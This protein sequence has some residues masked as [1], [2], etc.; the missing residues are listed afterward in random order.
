MNNNDFNSPN[1][2]DQKE[3]IKVG[4]TVRVK[5]GAKTYEGI[6]LA[7]FVYQ[8]EHKVLQ[9]N[10]NRVVITYNGS[11]IAAMNIEDLELVS[12]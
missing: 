11:V 12:N 1:Q 3:E 9:I 2:N 7:S 6:G 5:K 10:G 4:S 8:G